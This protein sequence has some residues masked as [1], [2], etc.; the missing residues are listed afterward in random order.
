MVESAPAEMILPEV[1]RTIRACAL[2]IF[3]KIGVNK[4][5]EKI[6]AKKKLLTA[7]AIILN[8]R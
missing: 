2:E 4:D 3:Q 7:R 6:I 8:Q 5:A 1:T